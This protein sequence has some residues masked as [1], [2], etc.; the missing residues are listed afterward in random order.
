MNAWNIGLV[1]ITLERY[2]KIVHAVGHRKYY[3]DWMTK[4]GVVVPWI[5][6]ICTFAI[7]AYGWIK[8]Q[9]GRCPLIMA[10]PSKASIMVC[11]LILAERCNCVAIAVTLLSYDVICL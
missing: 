10:L 11:I 8:D 2:F 9:P 4:V 7:P 1:V 6:G 5:S 3:R